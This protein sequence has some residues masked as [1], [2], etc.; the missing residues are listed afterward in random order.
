MKRT[1][2]GDNLSGFMTLLQPTSSSQSSD[3]DSESGAGS[4]AEPESEPDSDSKDSQQGGSS[5]KQSDSESADDKVLS[6]IFDIFLL[7]IDRPCQRRPCNNTE[8]VEA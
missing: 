3:N 8:F 7:V 5:K 1:R 6:C 2:Y 4:G